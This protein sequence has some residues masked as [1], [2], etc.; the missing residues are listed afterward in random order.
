MTQKIIEWESSATIQQN[1]VPWYC[2]A[3]NTS[4]SQQPMKVIPSHVASQDQR[5]NQPMYA[6]L[7]RI[8]FG[9]VIFPSW[10]FP[11]CSWKYLPR[12]WKPKSERLSKVLVM[13]VVPQHPRQIIA[14]WVY[15]TQI[16]VAND[17]IIKQNTLQPR[18]NGWGFSIWPF[19]L[20]WSSVRKEGDRRPGMK[21]GWVTCKGTVWVSRL[22]L[23]AHNSATACSF[24]RSQNTWI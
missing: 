3:W 15:A 10:S 11:R 20:T 18:N 2:F 17:P 14:G 9:Q 4:S 8:A 7:S 21:S 6:F 5:I 24:Q 1:L 22:S 19:W 16:R 13:M 12:Q 23:R